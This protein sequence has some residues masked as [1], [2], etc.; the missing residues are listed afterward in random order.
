[1]HKTFLFLARRAGLDRSAFHSWWLDAHRVLVEQVP[2]LRRY[3]ASLEADGADAPFDGLAELWFDDARA[4]AA[5]LASPPGRRLDK[6]LRAHAA[7]VERVEVV[8]HEFLNT[9]LPAP[10]KLIAALKR[11]PKLTRAQFASWWLERHAPLVVVFPELRRYC[12]NIVT[13]E[14]ECFADG[15]AEVAFGDLESLR[16]ITSSAEVKNVQGDSQAHTSERYR[17]LVAEHRFLG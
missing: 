11:D 14:R 6:D 12:V 15:V 4:A 17:L 5:A 16:R 13:D 1:M 8:A 3:T 9:G 10:C 2:G 7:R